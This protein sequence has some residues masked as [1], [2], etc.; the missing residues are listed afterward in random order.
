MQNPNER[1]LDV[2][3]VILENKIS[4]MD[5]KSSED[6]VDGTDAVRQL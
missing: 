2:G 6:D 5:E 1:R 3:W 4:K